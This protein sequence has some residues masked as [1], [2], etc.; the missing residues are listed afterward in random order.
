MI[1]DENIS[2]LKYKYNVIE[3]GGYIEQPDVEFECRTNNGI[4]TTNKIFKI[5]ID[6]AS[7]SSPITYLNSGS[8]VLN[9]LSFY[10]IFIIIIFHSYKTESSGWSFYFQ[11]KWIISK[12]DTKRLQW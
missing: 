10:N 9:Q 7:S 3:Q 4:G 11:N 2:I 1:E 6:D 5:M 12:L 8:L